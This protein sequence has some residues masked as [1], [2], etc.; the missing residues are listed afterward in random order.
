[1][2]SFPAKEAKRLNPN[3]EPY[4]RKPSLQKAGFLRPPPP[5]TA[6][7]QLMSR[8]YPP[9]MWCQTAVYVQQYPA[10]SRYDANSFAF[11][12][13]SDGVL[14]GGG[15][16]VA[17]RSSRWMK[18]RNVSCGPRTAKRWLP[19]KRVRPPSN[20][21]RSPRKVKTATMGYAST[22]GNDLNTVIPFPVDDLELERAGTTTVMIKNIPNQFR[23]VA[24]SLCCVA[25][26]RLFRFFFL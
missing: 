10:V 14:G 23:S 18:R 22:S 16:E 26:V 2:P 6:R 17:G 5:V 11:I 7:L 25:C 4:S 8:V 21:C 9:N 12:P 3:A 15:G 13:H 19:V 24:I 20:K 1:M